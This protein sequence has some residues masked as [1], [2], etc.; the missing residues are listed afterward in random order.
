[1]TGASHSIQVTSTKRV[2][3]SRAPS[4]DRVSVT[5]AGVFILSAAFYLWTTASTLPLSLHAGPSDRYNLLATAFLHFRLSVG[6]APAALLHAA[7]P[8]NPAVIAHLPPAAN[9]AGAVN[10]DALYNG[11]L[12]FVWGPA[13]ALILLV[14]MHLLGFEP[15]SSVTVLIFAVAGLFFAL[16]TLRIVIKQIS[17]NAPIW[18]CVLAGFA[19]SLTS[20]VPYLLRTPDVTTDTLAGGY[21]FAM[22]GIWLATSA[23]AER[24]ASLP[25][26]VLM[27]LCFGL[28][29]N[30][31]P[32]LGLT[33]LLLVVVYMSLRGVHSRRTLLASLALPIGVCIILLLAYNQARFDN[34]FEVGSRHQ[35]GITETSAAPYGRLSYVLPGVGFYALTP[36]RF[37]ILFPFIHLLTPEA[38]APPGLDEPELTGGLLPL[39]PIVIFIAALPWIW[40]RRPA[41][42]GRVGPLLV[43]IAG[44]GLAIPVIP[45]YQFYSPTERYES[46][47]A[48]LLVLGGLAA[49]LS[50]SQGTSGYRRRLLQI[51]GGLLAAWGC[52]TGI[53]ISFDG[54]VSELSLTHPATWRALE[55]IGSPLSTAM[56]VAVGHPVIGGIRASAAGIERKGA[57]ESL[58]TSISYFYLS[59]DERAGLTIVSPAAGRASLVASVSLLP[60]ANYGVRVEGPGRTSARYTLPAN[61][62]LVEI[63]L[64]LT[65]GLNRLTIK[66]AATS[67]KRISATTK[68]MTFGGLSV[69]PVQ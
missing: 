29:V 3:L 41:W 47:F 5:L 32:P 55:D 25:R 42:L 20:V 27:S 12:Y 59:P 54:S 11:R 40:W 61:G 64:T 13:P 17:S 52:V 68:I 56:A 9:D 8:Y 10:D 24:K 1:M 35:L 49:W 69:T 15:S 62:G 23:I 30:S 22:A 45:A 34:P 63:P 33:A 58:S 37:E 43:L 53:A 31:R 39:A 46:D 19:V 16:S 28:A 50:L 57:H 26:L 65:R 2:L 51:V 6:P 18:M 66:P 21:C 7:N 4:T 60:G 67:P 36:P 48:T 44:I 14:P 38:T